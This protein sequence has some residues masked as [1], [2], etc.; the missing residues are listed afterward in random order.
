MNRSTTVSDFTP[1]DPGRRRVLQFGS[2]AAVLPMAPV[3]QAALPA[4]Q[5]AAPTEGF[6]GP[7][8]YLFPHWGEPMAYHVSED[9][10]APAAEPRLAFRNPHDGTL[11]W[12]Q[13]LHGEALFAGK[14][15][16]PP[17]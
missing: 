12:S 2:F 13:S 16:G 10:D 7:G 11:L 17:V 15:V 14:L 6:S 9:S 1:V 8:Y 3:L 4:A 5:H